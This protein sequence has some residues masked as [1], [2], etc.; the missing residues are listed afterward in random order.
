MRRLIAIG[1]GLLALVG[2]GSTAEA[3][4]EI[5]LGAISFAQPL[6]A[7]D[8]VV[9]D[10]GSARAASVTGGEPTTVLELAPLARDEQDTEE[11]RVLDA[12]PGRVVAGRVLVELRGYK[13]VERTPARAE[14]LVSFSGGPPTMLANCYGPEDVA[15]DVAVDAGAVAY[16]DPCPTT[17]A[18]AGA[19]VVHA[20]TASGV[21]PG[22]TVPGSDTAGGPIRLAGRFIAFVTA[23]NDIKPIYELVVWDWV[24][25]AEAYRL[26]PGRDLPDISSWD[27]Q[28]DG[29][30]AV[31]YNSRE[32]DRQLA[33]VAWFS[34]EEP[35][36]HV[37]PLVAGGGASS[38][39]GKEIRIAE[40][41]IALTVPTAGCGA[42]LTIASLDGASTPMAC[43]EHRYREE[44]WDFDGRRVALRASRCSSTAFVVRGLEETIAEPAL[45]TRCPLRLSRAIVP[46][47]RLGVA[48][49]R[50]GCPIGCISS[51]ALQPRGRRPGDE[52]GRSLIVLPPTGERRAVVRIGL[53]SPAARLLARKRRMPAL[54]IGPERVPSGL[55]KPRF[56]SVRVTLKAP[57]RSRR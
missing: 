53:Y 33:R 8:Q 56:R 21:G 51:L 46:V 52:L 18:P 4:T 38:A 37:L 26:R 43:L 41:R 57:K 12:A 34:V 40:D 16:R 42:Q 39:N 24:A 45:P 48:R 50:V 1:T 27:L 55:S 6:L 15:P 31:A 30:A 36:A 35:R 49:L 54:L 22:S 2:Y 29:K 11:H 28:V 7:G 14:I 19:V 10:A 5:P 9:W 25:G 47:D 13:E 17:G 44:P 32:G 20:L 23:T 3:R